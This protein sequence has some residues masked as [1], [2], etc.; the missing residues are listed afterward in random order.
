MDKWTIDDWE[1]ERAA[2]Q[3]A[4][5]YLFTPMCGTCAVASKMLTVIEAMRPELTIG[6]ADLNFTEQLAY[7]YE[8]ESVPC[9]LIHRQGKPIEK[10]YAFQSV[11][12]LLEKLT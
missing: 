6:K 7:D 12:N 5:F 8:I 9:L 2:E 3:L 1:R 4:A 11:P 10:I